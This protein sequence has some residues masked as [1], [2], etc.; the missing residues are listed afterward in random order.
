MKEQKGVHAIGR[1]FLSHRLNENFSSSFWQL[2]APRRNFV[3]DLVPQV[4]EN[5]LLL[6]PN[7][8]W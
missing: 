4:V 6:P 7:H 8:G 3:P 5:D 2:L 1:Y